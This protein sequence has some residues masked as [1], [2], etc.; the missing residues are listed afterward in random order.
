M[1][2]FAKILL[3]VLEWDAINH[4]FWQIKL[5]VSLAEYWTSFYIYY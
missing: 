4:P 5:L 2:D 1:N 3:L